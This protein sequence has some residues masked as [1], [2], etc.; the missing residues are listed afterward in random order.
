MTRRTHPEAQRVGTRKVCRKSSRKS[1]LGTCVTLTCSQSPGPGEQRPPASSE[2][3]PRD[4][5][6]LPRC[7]A[8]GAGRV[9]ELLGSD[10]SCKLL[11][12][13]QVRADG[14]ECAGWRSPRLPQDARELSRPGPRRSAARVLQC[15]ASAPPTGARGRSCSGAA[16]P[17]ESV[18]YPP[19]PG[20]TRVR[21][22]LFP[23]SV[24]GL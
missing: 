7:V 21:F 17:L 10:R 19:S 23:C 8:Q 24:P 22:P 3:V 1:H 2:L 20:C 16:S 9:S 12:R 5:E 4:R 6:A 13:Q 14:R 11:R 15:G 18:D